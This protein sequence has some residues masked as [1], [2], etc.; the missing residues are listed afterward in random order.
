MD[1]FGSPQIGLA[2]DIAMK[3]VVSVQDD[4]SVS[5]AVQILQQNGFK[6]LPVKDERA[7]GSAAFPRGAFRIDC[8]R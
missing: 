8:L 3:K 1:S 6:Q 7:T 5:R 4:D 2:G